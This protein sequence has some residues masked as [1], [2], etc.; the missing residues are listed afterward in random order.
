MQLAGFEVFLS[1][2]SGREQKKK[3][4]VYMPYIPSFKENELQIRKTNLS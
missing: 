4:S 3:R 1:L 2:H